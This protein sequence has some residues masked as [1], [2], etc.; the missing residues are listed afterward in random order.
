MGGAALLTS[1][2]PF[3]KS[4]SEGLRGLLQLCFSM[5]ASLFRSLLLSSSDPM[6]LIPSKPGLQSAEGILPGPFSQWV[7]M[8]ISQCSPADRP[9]AELIGMVVE[10]VKLAAYVRSR[11]FVDGQ[12]ETADFIQ[13]AFVIENQLEDWQLRQTGTWSVVEEVVD[14][15][16]FPAEAVFEGRYHV[17]SD[18]Y[19]ARV[20]NYYRWVRT[21]VNQLLLESIDRFPLSSS[22][23]MAP[24]QQQLSQNCV[25]RLSRDT[26]VSLPTHYRHPKM[27]ESQRETFDKVQGGAVIGIAGI[28]V[29]L[30]QTMV[31]ACAPGIPIQYRNWARGIIETIWLHMGMYQA[32]EILNL[33]EKL[34][35]SETRAALGSPVNIKIEGS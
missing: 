23:I 8:S 14:A 29:L 15:K 13:R 10:F 25:V 35:E 33:V 5:I 27:T 18:M 7:S 30:S 4:Q 24:T 22:S 26:L 28:P 19:V 20:W 32:K 31:A 16:Y 34:C 2:L 11:P 21:L 17:Y 9:S 12:P 6:S 1:F 3:Q